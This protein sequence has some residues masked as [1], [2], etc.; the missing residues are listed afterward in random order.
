MFGFIKKAVNNAG[1]GIVKGLDKAT[2]SI[3]KVPVVGG[4]LK[5][6][7]VLT[8]APIKL[9]GKIAN[10]D[11]LTGAVLDHFKSQIGAA[12]D[13]APYV[14]T[15]IGVVPGLG[16]VA[17]GAI[18]AG[19]ALANGQPITQALVAATKGALPGGPLAQSVFS[20]A[21][22]AIQGKPIAEIG[23]SAIPGMNDTQ[24]KAIVAAVNVA[25]DVAKGKKVTDTVYQNAMKQ[26]PNE[27]QKALTIGIALGH[28]ANLQ[29][30]LVKNVKLDDV[31][32]FG[33]LG[34]KIA[35]KNPVFNAGLNTLKDVKVKTGFKVGM[36]LSTAKLKPIDIVAVRAKL[37][38]K[39]KKG[40]DMAMATANGLAGKKAPKG[41]KT[42]A[43]KFGYYA[44][45]GLK[46]NSP[47]NTVAVMK[48]IAENPQSK[49]GLKTAAVVIKQDAVWWKQLL[50]KIGIE[51]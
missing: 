49:L 31:K 24:R 29:K 19:L 47:K 13:V 5:G 51:V 8:V 11:K 23:L 40:F 35:P 36:G 7:F 32:A 17:S 26:L 45:Q 41:L 1:K 16:T 14:Q 2:K 30:T 44:T 10:G 20:V 48:T 33:S 39:Q 21:E 46:G 37:P 15:V 42:E 34:G 27:A 50:K 43:E 28:G 3:G 18:G 6:V 25:K 38:P 22:S 12:K 9:T 4:G